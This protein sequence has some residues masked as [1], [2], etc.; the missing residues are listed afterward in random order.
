MRNPFSPNGFLVIEDLLD[1]KITN[2][3]GIYGIPWSLDDYDKTTKV[4]YQRLNISNI[5]GT[6][7]VSTN[8]DAVYTYWKKMIQYVDARLIYIETSLQFPRIQK[9]KNIGW[10]FNGYDFACVSGDLYSA[11]QQDLLISSIPLLDEW[12]VKLNK[13]QLFASFEDVD[14][15]TKSRQKITNGIETVGDFYIVRVYQYEELLSQ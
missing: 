2:Y 12:K 8:W 15:F 1:I 9:P 10:K 6:A 5:P 13:N 7:N 11:I 4:D 14:A 3:G